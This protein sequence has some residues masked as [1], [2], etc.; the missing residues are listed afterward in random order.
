MSALKY[1]VVKKQDVADLWDGI[2][3][4]VTP[5]I[6]DKSMHNAYAYVARTKWTNRS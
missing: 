4:V 2:F 1:Q 3:A 6:T 5:I